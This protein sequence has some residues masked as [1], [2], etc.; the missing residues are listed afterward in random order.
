MRKERRVNRYVNTRCRE[1]Y[2]LAS[3]TRS[4]QSGLLGGDLSG[5]SS[6]G[7]SV[8]S[9]SSSP[10]PILFFDP[11]RGLSQKRGGTHTLRLTGIKIV[12]AN[13]E[14]KENR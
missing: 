8:S 13:A 5:R 9:S 4:N 1:R 12:M 10:I 14:H 2:E 11:V 6:V 3:D 7:Q